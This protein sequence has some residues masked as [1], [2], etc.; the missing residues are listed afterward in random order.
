MPSQAPTA[1]S[2][3]VFPAALAAALAVSS[4]IAQTETPA[5]APAAPTTRTASQTAGAT[6]KAPLTQAELEQLL[7]PIALYPDSLLSQ[8]LMASTYP[9]EVVQADRWV[10]AN[11]S[12]AGDAMAKQLEAQT[13]DPSVKS[14]VNFPE[15]LSLMSEKVDLTIKIGDAFL[16]QQGD[17][18]AT[19]QVLRNRAQTSGN[20][21][22]SE[23]LVVNVQQA[24]PAQTT[25]V[26]APPQVITIESSSPNV[27][28]VPTYNPTV[29]YG[30]WPYPAYPPY[31]YYPPAY[32][33]ARPAW[34]FGAGVAVGAAWGYAWGNCNW[35]R[36]DIDID[37][38][39]NYTRNTSINR[40]AYSGQL[41]S[42]S[43][44]HNPTHRQGAPY[45]DA[46][47]AQRFGGEN[48]NPS[49][50]Q[51][52]EQFRGRADAGRQEINRAGADNIRNSAAARPGTADRAAP[53]NRTSPSNRASPAPRPS[54]SSAFDGVQRG[55]SS[56]RMESQR[57][58]SS[59]NYS[60]PSS[61]SRSS[62]SGGSR[63]GGARGGG[64][65]R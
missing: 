54:S 53:A 29:V 10:K 61:P 7:A 62:V 2:K 16:A 48:R 34:A 22:S 5:R 63:G 49:A 43:W 42:G 14:L 12:L 65:R 25:I 20:L 30:G 33:A 59:R 26:Q 64:G 23:Q 41:G 15:Q 9:L 36:G 60:R 21:K 58:Q 37:V 11:K 6:S 8:I 38:N 39:R 4:A 13:W 51:S 27:I 35:G 45:R 1:I 40:S 47:T 52:R 57:G 50:V 44:Q 46:S 56:A 55:G 32:Y 28:Y 24:P 3:I 17:V 19:I 18:L 31:Y